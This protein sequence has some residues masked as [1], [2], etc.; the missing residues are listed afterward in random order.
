MPICNSTVRHS[1]S[2]SEALRTW[3]CFV[4]F[5]VSFINTISGAAFVLEA[6]HTSSK[7]SEGLIPLGGVRKV[8]IN[9]C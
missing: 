8:D 9:S 6:C 7:D 4:S 1:K 5:V 3:T 2:Y